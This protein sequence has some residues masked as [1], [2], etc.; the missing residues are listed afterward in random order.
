MGALNEYARKSGKGR[1][2]KDPLLSVYVLGKD[3]G[4]TENL[5]ACSI[6]KG[7]SYDRLHTCGKE[8]KFLFFGT[9]MRDCFTYTHHVEALLEVPYRYNRKFS[10]KI[11]EEGKETESSV[12]L[13]STYSNCVLNPVPIVHDEMEKRGMLH[14]ASAGN[15][16][17]CCFAEKDGFNVLE[18]LIV[19]NPYALTNGEFNPLV[20]DFNYNP[21]GTRVVSVL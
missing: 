16:S 6:G 11:R 10:G 20:R 17:L 5:S 3:P 15:G 7:S 19:K 14:K 18:E 13:Y 2:S 1:R 4:L 8:A 21:A 12:W 9:D